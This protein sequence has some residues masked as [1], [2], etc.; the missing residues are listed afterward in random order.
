MPDDW[1]LMMFGGCLRW[2]TMRQMNEWM[3]EWNEW[4]NERMNE[5]NEWMNE[6]YEWNEWNELY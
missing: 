5:W 6:W 3:N 1:C 2:M 4:M